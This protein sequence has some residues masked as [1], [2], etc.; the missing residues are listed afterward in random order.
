MSLSKAQRAG[1]EFC[2]EDYSQFSSE[3][4]SCTS[5]HSGMNLVTLTRMRQDGVEVS[6]VLLLKHHDLEQRLQQHE[7]T[8]SKLAP[9]AKLIGPP[10]LI[11]QFRRVDHFRSALVQRSDTEQPH[12]GLELLGEHCFVSA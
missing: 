11:Q 4:P 12:T 6:V 1:G 2:R 8:E 7:I 3:V 10:H 9:H 5:T